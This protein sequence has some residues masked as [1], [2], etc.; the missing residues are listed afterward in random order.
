MSQPC[1]RATK[2]LL[3]ALAGSFLLLGPGVCLAA[4]WTVDDL[5]L[6]EEA[7]DFALSADGSLIA[8]SQKRFETVDGEEKS[9]DAIWIRRRE[10]G[11]ARQMT[12]GAE[13]ISQLAFSADGSN[14]AF[15]SD[16][17]RPPG[18]S[19]GGEQVKPQ[20]W[21]LPMA[22]GEAYPASELDR[23]VNIFHWLDEETLI[24]V[25][26][27]SPS[28][29][30]AERK[31]AK[32]TAIVVDDAEHEPPVRLF[33]VGLDGTTER[34]TRNLDWIDSL[35]VSRD[36]RWAVV[37]VQ[38]SLS[39]AFDQRTP[40]HTYLIATADGSTTRLL[41]DS[42]LIP[43]TVQWAVDGSGF[44]F[45]NDHTTHPTLRMATIQEIYFFDLETRQPTRLELSWERA[46]GG[47]YASCDD[48]VIALLADGVRYRPARIGREGRREDLS[49]THATNLDSWLLAQDGETLVYE[50][51]SATRSPQWF[52]A[53]LAGDRIVDERQLTQLNAGY[54]DKST[55]RVEVIRW[56][57]ARGEE[58]EG[59][60]HYPLDWREGEQRALILDI[61]G[62]PASSDRDRWDQSWGGPNLLWRQRGAFV[63]QVN[64]HGSNNYGLEWVE[65]IRERYYELEFIDLESGVDA[66]IE[67]GLV[68]PER[69]ASSGW[70]NGGILTAHLITQTGRY[71]AAIVGAA[72]VE[73]LSDWASV[74][75]GAA[76][77][78]YYF[79][80]PPWEKTE[81]YLEKSPF[82]RLTEVTTPTLIHTGTEDRNVPPHQS[83]S[84]FRALQYL[85]K[86]KTRLVLYPGEPHGL[87]KIAHQRRKLAEDLA[88]FDTH[89]F[90]KK[91]AANPEIIPE[92]S[93]LAGLLARR[94]VAR[95]DVGSFGVEEA[96]VLLP[97]TVSFVGHEI[98]RFEVTRAQ[99]AAFEGRQPN[100]VEANLPAHDVSFEEAKAYVAWLSRKSGRSFRLPSREE[101]E[102]LA[103]AAGRGGNTLDRWVGYRPNPEDAA[104]LSASLSKLAG[105]APLL[106][107]VGS[108]PGKGDPMVFDL[109]GNLAEW[110]VETDGRG[111]AV[112]ASADR[113]TDDR[114]RDPASPVYV[115]LR[116]VVEE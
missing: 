21:I 113:S 66:L 111:V 32:D 81:N 91:P 106:L 94:R 5:I 23:P 95:T 42:E 73:W 10:G 109:D 80:G 62:G 69:L 34:L 67:R 93:L 87:L 27:E 99:L 40:P 68:D 8:W 15:L 78:H 2:S 13:Q 98:G 1:H 76:F 49:G 116:V 24:L 65:S 43:Y 26:Q 38:Q 101:A 48:G 53:R 35:A 84:L 52:V 39:Y 56:R 46:L 86:T 63:L 71:K 36:G 102:G 33:K 55:G 79:G 70:S 50:T 20:V 31:E 30:E 57:G 41:A 22:G 105:D 45:L 110:A 16:R 107:P 6:K 74:D 60:L 25:A 104:R 114:G 115:G 51:S 75:F 64:Y 17:E 29:W 88:W 96:G 9:F 97:E 90:A 85:G 72:D 77:D 7:D 28:A 83:W 14:L 108:L 4:P 12:H 11:D 19:A 61:H 82:F 47:D 3:L 58:V 103:K 92:G 112:G 44:Y 54:A 89:L 18:R 59:L 37:T 100:A